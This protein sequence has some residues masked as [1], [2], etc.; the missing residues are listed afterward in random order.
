MIITI[1]CGVKVMQGEKDEKIKIGFA[2]FYN[3]F[4]EKKSRFYR[5]LS[6][7]YDV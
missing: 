3:N 5:I 1:K 6:K 4:N 2:D 7:H